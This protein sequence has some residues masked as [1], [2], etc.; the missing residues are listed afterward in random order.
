ML[1]LLAHRYKQNSGLPCPAH[2][3][4]VADPTASLFALPD[5]PS[6]NGL[7]LQ[8]SKTNR[9]ATDEYAD[10]LMGMPMRIPERGAVGYGKVN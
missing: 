9:E 6:T 2:T 3:D 7:P 8:Y 4:T 5:P 10:A 1:L